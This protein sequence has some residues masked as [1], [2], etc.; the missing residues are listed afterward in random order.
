M[1]LCSN[2]PNLLFIN[3]KSDSERD[4][5]TSHFPSQFLSIPILFNSQS[6]NKTHF[7]RFV[8]SYFQSKAVSVLIRPILHSISY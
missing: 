2:V 8:S 3:S 1:I 6:L 7:I 5:N 4:F